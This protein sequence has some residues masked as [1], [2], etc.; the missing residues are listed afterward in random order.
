MIKTIGIK[1]AYK[2]ACVTGIQASKP[3]PFGKFKHKV[4]RVSCQLLKLGWCRVFVSAS[5]S[6]SRDTLQTTNCK[7]LL[8]NFSYRKLAFF[9]KLK[10]HSKPRQTWH[11]KNPMKLLCRLFKLIQP[12]RELDAVMKS[13]G[14]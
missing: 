4:Q 3:V 11:R 8:P 2:H 5:L 1:K 13:Y 6:R 12:W 14:F 9:G 7:K 10:N